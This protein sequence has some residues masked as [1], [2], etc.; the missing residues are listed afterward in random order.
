MELPPL[1]GR[2]LPGRDRASPARCWPAASSAGPSCCRG[3]MRD[4][5]RHARHVA[6]HSA[7]LSPISAPPTSGAATY[8][9]SARARSPRAESRPCCA[10]VRRDG[11]R[12]ARLRP[13]RGAATTP[14]TARTERDLAD[15]R[16]CWSGRQHR[17][18]VLWVGSRLSSLARRR[19]SCGRVQLLLRRRLGAHRRSASAR[20]RNPSPA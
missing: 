12:I 1:F 18:R 10:A 16:P 9:T 4:R 13:T 15:G 19:R 14:R 7:E 6:R 3:L 5:R 11:R 8:G 17:L 20:R 2:R